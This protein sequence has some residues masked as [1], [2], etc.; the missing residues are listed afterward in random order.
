[1]KSMDVEDVIMD[2]MFCL[3]PLRSAFLHCLFMF[4]TA[5]EFQGAFCLSTLLPDVHRS[6]NI[7][8]TH[9]LLS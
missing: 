4:W 9:K 3:S 5:V 1:M 7:H 8:Y 2:Y 6:N